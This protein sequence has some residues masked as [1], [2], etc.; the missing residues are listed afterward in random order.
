MGTAYYIHTCRQNTHK[1]KLRNLK[2][3]QKYLKYGLRFKYR[4]ISGSP[5]EREY[6][7]PAGDITEVSN[8]AQSG[9]DE[10]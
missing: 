5:G 10:G 1:Y 7:L 4:H 2:I 9:V 3:K 6:I 8:V